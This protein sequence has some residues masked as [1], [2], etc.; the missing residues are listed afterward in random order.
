MEFDLVARI[1]QRAPARADVALGIGDDAALLRPTPG[2]ELV[3]TA[4]T[5]NSGVHFPPGTAPADLGWKTLAVS[6]SDLAAMGAQPRWCLLSLSLPQADVAWLDAL[7][8]GLLALADAH[9]VTLVGGDTTR[10]PLSLSL[11]ALGEVPAGAALRRDGA[12]VGDEV[13]ITGAPGDAALALAQWRAGG[14]RDPLLRARL[15]RPTPRVAAGLALRGLASACIDVSDGLAADLG[16]VLRASGV[17]AQLQLAALPRSP[18]LG[19]LDDDAAWAH[20]VGGGDDYELCFTAPAARRADVEA[21]LARAG[22]PGTCIGTIEA[23]STLRLLDRSGRAWIPPHA[24]WQ[25]FAEP[26]A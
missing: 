20:Q 23:G 7:L 25:H 5:L 21:A 24:G 22:T 2:H 15:D 3:V 6:L 9:D 17:G 10:G 19:A 26:A 18:A 4:D 12:R 14:A 8:D 16:H 11:T 13:W 1:R